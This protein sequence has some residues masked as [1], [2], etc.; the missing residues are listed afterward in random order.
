MHE[1]L[2]RGD[3]DGIAQFVLPS[4]LDESRD[5]DDEAATAFALERLP[6]E[7]FLLYVGA[8]RRIKGIDA[9]FDAYG[10]L[11]DPPPLVMVGSFCA[12]GPSEL[13]PNVTALAKI[14]HAAVMAAWERALFGV[15]PSLLPEPLGSVVHEAMSRGKPVI[16]TTPSGHSDMIV[17]GETGLLVPP[18]DVFALRRA[19][20]TLLAHPDRRERMGRAARE[21]AQQFEAANVLPNIFQAVD[22]VAES[23]RGSRTR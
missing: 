5:D 21:R 10:Q 7:P 17:D 13:P 18:G 14:P 19:M 11:H 12:D 22:S 15:M 4:F 1:H 6:A 23:H 20:E 8:F 16:G 3:G 9:L 2:L